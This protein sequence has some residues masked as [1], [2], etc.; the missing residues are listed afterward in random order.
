M[1]LKP[2]PKVGEYVSSVRWDEV[3]GFRVISAKVTSI[4]E[5]AKGKKVRAPKAFYPIDCKEYDFAPNEEYPLALADFYYGKEPLTVDD[6][7][8]MIE[9]VHRRVGEEETT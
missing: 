5:T 6:V 3:N 1:E 7:K 4:T 9:E 2:C 8:R